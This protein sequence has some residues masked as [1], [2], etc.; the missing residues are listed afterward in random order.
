MSTA[1]LWSDK[2]K[3][4]IT[5]KG[6]IGLGQCV[7]QEQD[8]ICVFLDCFVPFILRQDGHR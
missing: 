1:E 3:R 2:K 7:L 5:A 6:Y 4:F 8:L